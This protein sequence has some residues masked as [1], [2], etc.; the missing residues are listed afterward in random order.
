[1]EKIVDILDGKNDTKGNE[2][3]NA[4]VCVCMHSCMWWGLKK[5]CSREET[6]WEEEDGE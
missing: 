2:E 5:K 3:R 1:M 6:E 4:F